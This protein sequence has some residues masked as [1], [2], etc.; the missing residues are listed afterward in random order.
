MPQRHG[1]GPGPVAALTCGAD[2]VVPSPLS[3]RELVLRVHAV[4][5]RSQVAGDTRDDDERVLVC[6]PLNVDTGSRRAKVDGRIASLTS[7]E[8]ALLAFLMRNPGVSFSRR[9]LLRQVWCYEVGD[10]ST[11][12]VHIRRVRARSSTTRRGRR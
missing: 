7:V 6:G 2:D 10:T 5:R 11:V 12:S 1:R 8:L 9:E 4:L 3:F